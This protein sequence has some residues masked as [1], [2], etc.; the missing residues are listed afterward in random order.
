M[1]LFSKISSGDDIIVE[2]MPFQFPVK[3]KKGCYLIK[4]APYGYIENLTDH[5]T[6]LLDCLDMYVAMPAISSRFL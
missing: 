4:S 6:N 5:I 3:D 1:A 2:E